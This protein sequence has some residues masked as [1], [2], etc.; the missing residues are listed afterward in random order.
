MVVIEP[1][2]ILCSSF[3]VR[4]SQSRFRIGNYVFVLPQVRGVPFAGFWYLNMHPYFVLSKDSPQV[5]HNDS[6][7][8]NTGEEALYM[9]STMKKFI[10]FI[11]VY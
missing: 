9:E 3:G 1:Y 8:D 10:F 6:L 7:K 5:D 4:C 11:P 2:T